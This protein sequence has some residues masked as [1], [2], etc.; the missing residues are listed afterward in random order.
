MT[1]RIAE[2]NFSLLADRERREEPHPK[3]MYPASEGSGSCAFYKPGQQHSMHD[4]PRKAQGGGGRWIEVHRVEV[5]GHIRIGSDQFRI[6]PS[7]L[8]RCLSL[9]LISAHTGARLRSP[10][11]SRFHK[12]NA[13]LHP[14]L[15]G[16][17][18]SARLGGDAK[19]IRADV[20]GSRQG[21]GFPRQQA[22]RALDHQ[23][24]L[25]RHQML[26]RAPV[27]DQAR[28]RPSKEQHWIDEWH[29]LGAR[30]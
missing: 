25:N 28:Q 12:A 16:H 15:A 22:L 26:L 30:R 14:H 9:K 17:C 6:Q 5:A 2:P 24:L 11:Q 20:D 3:A 19:G 23:R 21:H 29:W 13:C 8:D 1:S 10:K 18:R 7:R 4:R 27:D